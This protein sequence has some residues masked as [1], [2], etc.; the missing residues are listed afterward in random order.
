MSENGSGIGEQIWVTGKELLGT[1]K[2]YIDKG[3]A[4]ALIIRNEEGKKLL[5]IPLTAGVAIGGAALILAPFFTAIAAIA[6]VATKLKVEVVPRDSTPR[7]GP[8]PRD[9]DEPLGPRDD[10]TYRSGTF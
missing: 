5:E 3:N 7:E 4:R 10:G 1:I 9:P 6:G 8:P 2:G